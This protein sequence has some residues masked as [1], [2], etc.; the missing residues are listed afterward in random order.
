M[1]LSSK[2]TNRAA[3]PVTG[4]SYKA[5]VKRHANKAVGNEIG[6]ATLVSEGQRN[7]TV[8]FTIQNTYAAEK[9]VVVFPGMLTTTTEVENVAGLPNVVAILAEGDNA[10]DSSDTSKKIVMTCKNLAIAQRWMNYNPTRFG[11]IKVQGS[12]AAQ[13]SHE[14]GVAGF[15]ITRNFGAI[16]KCPQDYVS[17]DQH[18]SLIA[19][20]NDMS[21]QLD[22]SSV[23]FVDLAPNAS[24]SFSMQVLCE[25]NNGE[26]LAEIVESVEA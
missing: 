11:L 16:T 14:F 17:A 13:M 26:A 25:M 10:V 4:V 23:L 12:S 18:Q 15:G 6:M 22:A 9:R 21:L 20:I 8:N 24:V 5:L 19:E 1:K 2:L 3:G 7:V